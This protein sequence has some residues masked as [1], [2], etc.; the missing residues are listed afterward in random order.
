MVA[1]REIDVA[2]I[3]AGQAGLSAAY[4]LARR[5][6][7][8]ESG[9]VVLDAND[10]PGGA[11]R[12]RWDSL[13]LGSAHGIHDLP[14][15]PLGTPDPREPASSV[16]SRYY[17]AYEA[18]FGLRVQRPVRV[19]K[20]SRPAGNR[21]RITT[22]SG[23]WLAKFV[24][25]A[26]GTWDKPYWPAYPGQ[27]DFRGIQLH[28]RDFRSAADFAGRRVLVVGGG[29][30]ALQFL[31]QL[32]EAGAQTAWSTRRP[33]EFTRRPFDAEW[34]RGVE[35]AVSERT[36]AGLPPLSVVAATGLPLTAQYQK[37][38][39]DGVL[40]SRGPLVRLTPAG[41]VF[42]DGSTAA[43]DVIL[44]ATG[45]RASLGHLA[46]LHLREPGGGI[47]M[48]GPRVV[49]LPQLFLVGYGE[50]A[51]TLGATRAGRAAALAALAALQGWSTS[52]QTNSVMVPNSQ[53]RR[54]TA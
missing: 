10:G 48:D 12:H 8:P 38:I 7:I 16:V 26:T 2:V 37:G 49:R 46:S 52:S 4:Y 44:W 15:F 6:L 19:R 54:S 18:E 51:S 30:S 11:W 22:D 33:P 24:I 25:N 13:T 35:R 14:N 45:F 41:A 20:V 47:R 1:D 5:G 42:E 21:L 31:L 3:G 43:A 34:G 53:S 29:T 28:T 36:R 40:T 23:V 39:D 9:F 27:Q 32:H 50:S 17:G